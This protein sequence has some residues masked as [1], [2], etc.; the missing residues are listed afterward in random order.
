MKKALVMVLAAVFLMTSGACNALGKPGEGIDIT[1]SVE[2]TEEPETTPAD[3]TISTS[4]ETTATAETSGSDESTETSASEST[5]ATIPAPKAKVK[6][7]NAVSKTFKDGGI[8]YKYQ[9]PKV[10]ISG[11]STSAAN[12]K[13]KKQLGKY[14]YKGDEPY[15]I[16]YT[17]RITD[18]LVSILVSVTNVVIDSDF[19]YY[20]YNISIKSGKL[21]KDKQVVKLYGISDKKF[22]S[23][24]KSTYKKAGGIYVKSGS[25]AKKIRNKNLKRVSYKY[26]EPYIGAGGHL[27]F[28]GDVYYPG[29]AGEGY[30]PFDAVKKKLV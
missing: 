17:Y 24:V 10:T 20:A 26:L 25:E 12:K 11:K 13:M 5:Q 29:G 18:K 3:T 2:S 7:T 23:M 19:D 4:E 28:L 15:S 16:K 27:C 21:I 1:T 9:I 22:F 14:S 8:K 6:V 30:L